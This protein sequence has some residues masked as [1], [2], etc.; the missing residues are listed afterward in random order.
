M[1]D[2]V[3]VSRAG[4]LG[5]AVWFVGSWMGLG[6]DGFSKVVRFGRG[7]VMVDSGLL[8]ADAISTVNATT[9]IMIQ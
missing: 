9:A 6:V 8:H 5:G 3:I 7:V 4:C 2:G 1:A